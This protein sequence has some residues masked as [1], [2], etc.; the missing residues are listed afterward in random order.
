MERPPVAAGIDNAGNIEMTMAKT[1]GALDLVG[2]I[3][4]DLGLEI[5]VSEWDV[6]GPPTSVMVRGSL[7]AEI[8]MLRAALHARADDS[9]TLAASHRVQIGA[10]W[11][12]ATVTRQSVLVRVSGGAVLDQTVMRSYVI[13]AV[14]QA[15]GLVRSESIS[16]DSEGRVHDLT[17]RS[18]GILR[19]IETPEVEVEILDSDSSPQ[20]VSPAVFCAVAAAAWCFAN[21]PPIL[22]LTAN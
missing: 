14:H 2:A 20:P 6:P 19:S 4:S 17:V 18:F 5:G 10:A 22:P 15:L 7:R 1:P 11:A 13:G 3:A 12:E 21:K 8:E 9:A 16:V